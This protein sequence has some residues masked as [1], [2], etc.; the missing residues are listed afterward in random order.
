LSESF[1]TGVKVSAVARRH[2]LTT[3]HLTG[4]RCLAREG[5]L[6]LPA[7]GEVPFAKLVVGEPHD[8]SPVC[9]ATISIETG[10]LVVRMPID[11]SAA[12]LGDIEGVLRLT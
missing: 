6:V 7:A 12:R 4:W 2:G 11:I 9:S 5:R 1:E 10:G 8:T 3:Q